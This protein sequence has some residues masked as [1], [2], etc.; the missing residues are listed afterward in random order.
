MLTGNLIV[1]YSTLH[2]TVLQYYGNIVSMYTLSPQICQISEN[3]SKFPKQ[4]I[5][6]EIAV[7]D[8]HILKWL[9]VEIFIAMKYCTIAKNIEAISNCL[10]SINFGSPCRR[11]TEKQIGNVLRS[12]S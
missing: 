5:N 10:C 11:N 12:S 1:N 7:W 9:Y 8:Q 2:S 6:C 4:N 3:D